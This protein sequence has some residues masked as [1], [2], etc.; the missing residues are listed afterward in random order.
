MKNIASIILVFLLGAC[1]SSGGSKA[2]EPVVT[3]PT[4]PTE[5][6][7]RYLFD[8][9]SYNWDNFGGVSV[10]YTTAPFQPS[11]DFIS[12]DKYKIAD[13]GFL[14][15]IVSG[16]HT[17]SDTNDGYV[18]PGAWSGNAVWIEAD[19]NGDGHVDMFSVGSYA[20]IESWNPD[21]HLMAW[22]NDGNG[23]FTLT[24]GIFALP[25]SGLVVE[26]M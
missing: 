22:I 6:D 10:T 25:M 12:N 7:E 21:A 8:E 2:P 1:A 11:S 26:W 19:L 3:P 18:E 17:G 15:K 9:F 13:Y 4:T 24:P 23:H 5:T 14:R 20:G 16:Q